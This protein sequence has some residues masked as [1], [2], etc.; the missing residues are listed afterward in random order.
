VVDANVLSSAL[1][2]RDGTPAR[3]LR[4]W[5]DGAFEMVV[6]RRL[7]DE[8]ARAASYPRITSRIA[9]ERAARFVGTIR[10]MATVADDPMDPPRVRSRDSGDDYLVALAHGARS[11]LVTGDND[12][13]ALSG[14]IPVMSPRE[15][16]E[17]LD[18]E[19]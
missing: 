6:S 14:S 8:L 7:L 13:L 4:A 15:F 19:R 18:R 1:L 17:S 12:L 9:P 3:L 10:A 2:A 5:R 11:I 16:L